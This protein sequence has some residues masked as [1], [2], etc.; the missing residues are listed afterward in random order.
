MRIR[1]K[2]ILYTLLPL[3]VLFA[4]FSI[5]LVNQQ[6]AYE[7]KRLENKIERT[8]QLIESI[9]QEPLWN[10]DYNSVQINFESV[11]QDEEMVEI[12]FTDNK[13]NMRLF[14]EKEDRDKKYA[15]VNHLIPILK[16]NEILGEVS[17]TYTTAKI[18]QNLVDIRNRMMLLMLIMLTILLVIYFKISNIISKPVNSII[19]SLQLLD[20]GDL[21]HKMKLT[22]EDEFQQIQNHF[23]KMV[24]SIRISKGELETTNI[25]LVEEII[26][27]EKTELELS[28]QQGILFNIISNVPYSVFWKDTELTYVGCNENFAKGLDCKM[29]DIIGKNDYY[30]VDE[31]IA[32]FYAKLD[33]QVIQHNKPII[34]LEHTFE[35]RGKSVTISMS[36]VPLRDE[37]GRTIGIVGIYAD[38]TERKLKEKELILAKESAEIAN[39]A[40]TEF[41]ANMSHEIRTPMNGIMGMAEILVHTKLDKEQEKY[42][43]LIRTSTD[44]L[45]QVINDILDISKIEANKIELE[46]IEFDLVEVVEKTIDTFAVAAHTK[47][48]ELLYWLSPA[49]QT[50]LIGDPGRLKQILIN[51]IGNAVKFTQ[52]GEVR[53][54]VDSVEDRNNQTTLKF[55]ISDTG[56]GIPEDKLNAIFESFAQADNSYTRQYGGTGLGLSISKKLVSLMGGQLGVSSNLAQGSTFYFT[57]PFEYR[58]PRLFQIPEL[59]MDL[60]GLNVIVTDDNKSVRNI[61]KASLQNMGCKVRL[62]EDGIECLSAI[63]YGSSYKTYDVVLLDLH[64]PEMDGITVLEKLQSHLNLGKTVIMLINSIDAKDAKSDLQ[65]CQR[66]GVKHYLVKPLKITEIHQ[67]IIELA[68]AKEVAAGNVIAEVATDQKENITAAPPKPNKK[69][70]VLVVED[71]AI[72]QNI[73]RI[74]LENMGHEVTLAANGQQAIDMF[75]DIYDL[76]LMDIQMPGVD[77]LT[78]TKEIRQKRGGKRIPIIALTAHAQSGDKERFL[79]SGMDDYIAKPYKAKEFYRIVSK[80]FNNPEQLS[81]D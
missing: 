50:K 57:L 8:N 30:L 58:Y 41:L 24:K 73:T 5:Y 2:F 22:S 33:N 7:N 16:D 76:V 29:T 9:N 69:M 32:D 52:T 3:V 63:V 80:Y 31:E 26:E 56:I 45:L 68:T 47:G 43:G 75:S 34:E 74:L 36:R 18:E 12:K 49:I 70:K 44:S 28:Q 20:K 14:S 1:T 23:N 21:M 48:I 67:T 64:M 65:I 27:R 11:F 6:R 25:Q 39:K 71:H 62:A 79:E 40:K 46:E 54:R 81:D 4:A 78:A 19:E 35:R 61:L 59:P 17:V 77:G 55:N 38:I 13:G 51:I 42:V 37:R 53:L 10:V 60:R 72:N 15:E 66:L